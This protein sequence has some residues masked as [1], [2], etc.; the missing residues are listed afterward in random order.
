[1]SHPIITT[2]TFT[3]DV[4]SGTSPLTVNF[5][6]T[7]TSVDFI[8]GTTYINT[9]N[10]TISWDFGDGNTISGTDTPTHVYSAPGTY[11][12]ILTALWNAVT[13]TSDPTIITVTAGSSSVY[14]NMNSVILQGII[15]N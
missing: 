7:S 3:T 1:M 14:I 10:A 6:N 15:I 4:T 8:L 13:Y 5:T 11:S 2:S 12:V 9:S